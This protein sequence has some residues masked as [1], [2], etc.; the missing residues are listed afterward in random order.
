MGIVSIGGDVTKT[1]NLINKS[2]RSLEFN[3]ECK[4]DYEKNSITFTETETTTLKPKEVLPI[5]VRF[6]PK[7]RMTDF[8][9]EILLH[10]DGNDESRKLFTI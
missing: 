7:A 5:E 3:L 6:N 4:T 1:V 2:R 10:I 8:A 9:H